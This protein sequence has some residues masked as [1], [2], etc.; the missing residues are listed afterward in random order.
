MQ[1]EI[2]GREIAMNDPATVQH[3]DKFT[4]TLAHA[5]IEHILHPRTLDKLHL[6]CVL[7][8]IDIVDDRR[9]DPAPARL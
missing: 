2:R 3:A 8:C 5:Q 4:D 7:G 1:D 6:D 9:R